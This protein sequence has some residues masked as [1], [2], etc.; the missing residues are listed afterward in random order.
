VRRPGRR[1]RHPHRPTAPPSL[2]AHENAGGG[3]GGGFASRRYDAAVRIAYLVTSYRPPRQLLRLLSTLRRAQP[4][5][6]LVVHHDR[7]RSP[8]N[9]DLV[10]P[11]GGVDVLTTDVPV[12]WGDFSIVDITWRTLSW[13]VQH[14]GFDW[15]V[16]LSEQDYPVAPLD[17]LER[18]LAGSDVDAFIDATPVQLIDD[19]D[20]RFDFDRRYNYRYVKLPRLGLMS[21]LPSTAHRP[22][23]DAANYINFGLYKLQQKITVYRY[24]DALPMR[25]GVRP[26]HSPFSPAFPCWYGSQWMALSRR[27]AEA[28]VEFVAA[29][30]DY[31]RHYARTVIPD[32]SATATIVCNDPDL[33][34]KNEATHHV[35]FSPGAGHPEVF[36]RGDLDE[37]VESGRFFARKFDIDVDVDV[38]DALDRHLFGMPQP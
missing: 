18:R 28:V 16:F 34:V 25:L 8:W 9:E 22:I 38:L 23:A 11:I 35:R 5:S 37:L 15:V 29:H 20:L 24:P 30:D 36:R 13:M 2:F 4:E 27:S 10:A 26:R 6:A 32:E 7:L 19:G 1:D 21:R 14:R 12:S 3:G 31:V 33:R 17:V